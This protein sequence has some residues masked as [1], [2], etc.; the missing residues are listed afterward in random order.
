M[1]WHI[2]FYRYTWQVENAHGF[3]V[4]Y[5]RKHYRI[6]LIADTS[7][8][9]FVYLIKG[10]NLLNHN[11]RIKKL[12][13]VSTVLTLMTL[14]MA[15]DDIT[16]GNDYQD[17]EQFINDVSLSSQSSSDES[18]DSAPEIWDI[19]SEMTSNDSTEPLPTTNINYILS[20]FLL[21]FQL[22]YRTRTKF[23]GLNFRLKISNYFRG[24]LFLW[25]VNFRGCTQYFALKN[26]SKYCARV[27]ILKLTF[28]WFLAPSMPPK[29]DVSTQ[30][31]PWLPSTDLRLNTDT[32]ILEPIVNRCQVITDR[33]TWSR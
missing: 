7:K 1:L 12:K 20:Y 8:H 25:G 6:L 30:N 2:A 26:A 22:C 10:A 3:S 5:V 33:V 9:S 28:Q 17:S 21:F 23:R 19:E 15:I 27:C 29:R 14:L 13:E 4:H 31:L 32:N 24:S 18:N 11:H 16:N